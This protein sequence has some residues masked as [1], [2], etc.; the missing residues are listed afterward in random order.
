MGGF[1]LTSSDYPDGFPIDAEQLFF[2]VNKFWRIGQGY[3]ITT[4]ELTTITLLFLMLGILNPSYR[5][6]RC[7]VLGTTDYSRYSP[8]CENLDTRHTTPTSAFDCI[9][10]FSVE[11]SLPPPGT[12]FLAYT[13]YHTVYSLVD[14]FYFTYISYRD[15]NGQ[16]SLLPKVS[17]HR[18]MISYPIARVPSPTQEPISSD[19][20]E[21]QQRLLGSMT[22]LKTWAASLRNIS[23]DEDPDM[24]ISLR[25]TSAFFFPTVV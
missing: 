16:Q 13:V 1:I 23:P 3:P 17:P 19:N 7:S 8:N 5:P 22:N 11:R 24:E 18:E 20:M 4:L 25:W 14:T 21:L 12:E 15:R 9:F 10:L 2:P 6:Q